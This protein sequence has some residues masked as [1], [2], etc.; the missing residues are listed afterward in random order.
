MLT[1][2]LWQHLGA[3]PRIIGQTVQING[4]PHAV[5]GVIPPGSWDRQEVDLIVPL[6][7]KPEELH[8]HGARYSL[9]TGRLKPGVTIH[10]AQ[11]EMDAITAK[12]AQ[13][14]PTSNQ[15]W[16]ALVEPVK[17]DFLPI[18]RRRT[19]WLLLGAVLFLLLI[20][21]LNVTNLLLAKS[22]TRQKEVAI[23]DALG[24]NP[25]KIFA[26]FLTES[27]VLA[28]MGGLLGVTAGFAML[29]GLVAVMPPNALP[30]GG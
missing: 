20:A 21:C 5:V 26:Q 6:V 24:A 4:E 17:N 28:I 22:M 14:Y 9:V 18:E 7:F 8:D 19:L 11:A 23:R 10:Q 13:D 29:R 2:R 16:G 30:P 1:H 25:M 3:N 27:L 15:G 12:E